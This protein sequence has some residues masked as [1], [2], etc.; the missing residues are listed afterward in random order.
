[1]RFS[2]HYV[3]FVIFDKLVGLLATQK[4]KKAKKNKTL[5]KEI[6]I[7]ASQIRI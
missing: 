4:I 5:Q 3:Y 7:I 1:M 6:K 2:N